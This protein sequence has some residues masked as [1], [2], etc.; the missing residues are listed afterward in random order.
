[1]IQEFH[2]QWHITARCNLRCLHCYQ[3]TFAGEGE[4]DWKGL[5]QVCD[6]I[7]DGMKKQ[8]RRLTVTLT[9]GEPFLKKELWAIIDYLCGSPYVANIGIIT[10][11]FLTGDNVRQIK[12]YPLISDIYISLD[13]A[14]RETNDSIRGKGSFDA[15]LK[16]IRL[17]KS[18]NLPVFIMYTL[19]ERNMNEAAQLLDL[20]KELS[21]DGFILER[22]IPLGQSVRAKNE[23]IGPRR[24]EALYERIFGQCGAEYGRE[25]SARFHALKVEI[26]KSGAAD[27]YGAE[28]ITARDGCALLHDGTVLPCR[29]FYYPIGNL[30]TQPLAA[31]WKDSAVLDEIRRKSN[32]KGDCRDCGIGECRGCRALAFATTGDYLSP[33]PLCRLV[34]QK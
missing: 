34:L 24:L 17:L 33:D 28:C 7:L 14:S 5:K 20:C 29:R 25:D 9:G 4:L 26:D 12:D 19:L 10:N 22:F 8:D 3:D 2:L 30:T 15:S 11:G 18:F 23:L 16:G 27:L 21:A 6:N 31:I 13:G 32:L 1:M